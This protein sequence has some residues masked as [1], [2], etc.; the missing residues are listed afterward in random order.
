VKSFKE[1]LAGDRITN[2]QYELRFKMGTTQKILSEKNLTKKEAAKFRDAIANKV[3]YEMYYDVDSLL[4][5]HW[6]QYIVE[7]RC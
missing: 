4:G 1:V 6:R 5:A 3:V 2:T 7:H